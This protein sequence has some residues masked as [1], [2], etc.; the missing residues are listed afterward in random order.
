MFLDSEVRV[1]IDTLTHNEIERLQR[2]SP[3]SDILL[4]SGRTAEDISYMNSQVVAKYLDSE[5]IDFEYNI[6][7]ATQVALKK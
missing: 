6:P 4:P 5:K 1:Y 3:K 7:W 2:I